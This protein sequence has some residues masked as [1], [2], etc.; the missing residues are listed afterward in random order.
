MGL[1]FGPAE[2]HLLSASASRS[3]HLLPLSVKP[4]L[5]ANLGGVF[6]NILVVLLLGVYIWVVANNKANSLEEAIE[7]LME[8]SEVVY[9]LIIQQVKTLQA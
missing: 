3:V 6:F 1:S 5:C 8:Q 9:Q 4:T 7:A 2:R